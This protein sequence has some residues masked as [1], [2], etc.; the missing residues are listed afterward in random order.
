MADSAPARAGQVEG[1]NSASEAATCDD[2]T[3]AAWGAK[4]WDEKGW[5]AKD[6]ES[7]AAAARGAKA[8]M[9][10]GSGS[11]SGS[12]SG[13]EVDSGPTAIAAALLGSLLFRLALL[14]RELVLIEVSTLG[15]SIC[16]CCCCCCC[17]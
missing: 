9:P 5:D 1:R 2:T 16:P 7:W 17:C 3:G 10:P 14:G 15:C 11:G 8:G 4:D 12:G 6:E 13:T